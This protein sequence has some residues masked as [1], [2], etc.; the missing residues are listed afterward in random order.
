[1][2]FEAA[3]LRL[4]R[5]EGFHSNDPRDAGGETKYGISKR[6]YPHIDI[7][8]LTLGAAKDIYRLDYWHKI[9]A[10]ELPDAIRFDMFDLAVNSGVGAAVR[11][12]QRAAGVAVDGVLGPVT[13][14][15]V[16]AAEPHRLRA[17]LLG[18]RL[19]LMTDLSTWAV[20]SRG[21]ARRIASNLIEG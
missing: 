13:T 3:F 4:L 8:T 5:H 15:A 1:M 11:L 16:A 14:A 12:L 20:F 21:W 10:D 17:R 18:H 6:A 7:A 2:D 9:R 19:Q